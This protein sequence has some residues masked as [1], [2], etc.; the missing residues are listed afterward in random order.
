MM[1]LW[2]NRHVRIGRYLRG[3]PE[4]CHLPGSPFSK[5]QALEMMAEIKGAPILR[6]VRGELPRDMDALADAILPVCPYGPRPR[7]RG[8]RIGC[9]SGAGSMKMARA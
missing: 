6:G 4:G 3:S 5:K 8:Q 9:Q 2:S 1:P 7:R